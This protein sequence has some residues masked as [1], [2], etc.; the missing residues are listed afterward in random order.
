[1]NKKDYE[2]SRLIAEGV[3]RRTV[4]LVE[5]LEVFGSHQKW[6]KVNHKRKIACNC[7]YEEALKYGN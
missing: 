1:M 7:G 3:K 2:Y 6:C 5:A 4:S